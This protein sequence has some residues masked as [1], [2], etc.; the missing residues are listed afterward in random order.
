MQVSRFVG[1]TN[2][3][4]WNVT[5]VVSIALR[6]PVVINPTILAN[7][8]Y[9]KPF[10][11]VVTSYEATATS[12]CVMSEISFVNG[13]IVAWLSFSEVVTASSLAISIVGACPFVW[14]HVPD[15]LSSPC[16]CRM[17][18]R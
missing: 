16:R 5:G 2:S 7:V 4:P 1:L 6:R 9:C 10:E 11:I 14:R 17:A 3:R 18:P 8:S 13:S 15:D 12:R